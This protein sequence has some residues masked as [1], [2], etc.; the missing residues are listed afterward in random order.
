[1]PVHQAQDQ[2]QAD[3]YQS[4]Q[5]IYF[6]MSKLTVMMTYSRLKL[7]LAAVSLSVVLAGC[8]SA[9]PR[10][11]ASVAP[12]A[13][14]INSRL[15]HEQANDVTIYA[16]G[17]VGTPYRYGGN[18]PSSGFDCSGLIGH[19]YQSRAGVLSPRTVAKLSDWGNAVPSDQLRSGDLV[20]FGSGA[21]ASH[22][23]I[24]VGHGRFVHAPSTGGEVRLDRLN[25]KHWAAQRVSFRRP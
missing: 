20:L 13:V 11:G 17:L 12:A 7:A 23:G 6:E 8:G 14:E 19:V 1:V 4:N 10:P 21:G 2:F 25:A 9:P 24:Y 15:S 22:A 18:T 3:K 5:D 16:V